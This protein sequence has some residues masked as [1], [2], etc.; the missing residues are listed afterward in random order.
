MRAVVQR[1]LYSSVII[2]GVLTAEIDRGLTV[3]VGIKKGDRQKD[4]DY[5][6]DKII[7]LRIFADE[8]GKM[9]RSLVEINGSVLLISQFTLYGDVKHGRRPGFSDAEDPEAAEPLFKYCLEKL[10]NCGVNVAAGT[11]GADMKITI[12]NDGPCTILIDSEKLF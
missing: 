1:V 5:L 6:M 12:E 9:N 7:N 10:K 8:D 4:A 2:N 3:L 11:F